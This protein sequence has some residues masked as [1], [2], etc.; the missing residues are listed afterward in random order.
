MKLDKSR[1]LRPRA[2]ELI[3]G[4][5][6]TYAKGDD[7]Y[8][9]NAPGFI[10]RGQG[11][12][13][14]DVD[15]NEYIEY[16]SG[17]RSVTLGHGYRPVV[18]AVCRVIRDGTNFVRPAAIEIEAAEKV[19][20]LISTGE[21]IKF[22]KNGSDVTTAAVKLARAYTG[23]DLVAIC[24]EHPFFSTDDW[25]I[26]ATPMN[27]GIP[28]AI[29]SMTLKFHYN[30]LDSVQRLFDEYPGKIA[31]LFLEAETTTPP[32]DGFLHKLRDLCH[33]NGALMILDEMI[34]GFRWHRSGAQGLY[35]IAPDL[36]CFGKAL[37]N[38]MSVSALIGKREIMQLG[39]LSHDRQRVFL[40]ST[41]HGAETHH[42]AAAMAV[43]DAYQN[44]DVV[45]H[46]ERAGTRLAAGVN[47]VVAELGL[48]DHFQLAGRVSNLVFATLDPQKQRSQPF[49]TLFLQEMAKQ[50]I[51]CPSFVVSYAHSDTDIDRTIE[52]TRKALVVYQHALSDGIEKYL[53]GPSV[54]PVLRRYN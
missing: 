19:L 29:S 15:G 32:R 7:Q 16:G 33:R 39:G 28:H 6:H 24:A 1:Q 13:V 34:T 17:L 5:A 47:E 20:S 45:G 53:V 27:A 51:L 42:L 46:M 37:G 31:C 4:G 38:G 14:W 25:F 3:P 44:N 12:H 23:R 22:A 9:E 49:R 2:H 11:S 48:Q 21:M 10:A 35:D 43:V 26:G 18:D 52:A 40:L 36:S 41:T 8:P 30:D 54:K 50:G